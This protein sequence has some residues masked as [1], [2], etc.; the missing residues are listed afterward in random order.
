[1][2]K[3]GLR[4]A[5]LSGSTASQS[6]ARLG[7]FYMRILYVENHAVFAASVVGQFLSQHNVTVVPSL[8]AAR[9][10]LATDNF[11]LLLVD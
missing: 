1:M 6:V 2:K 10:A 8:A 11:D 9:Q 7:Q 4:L 5:L 3:P